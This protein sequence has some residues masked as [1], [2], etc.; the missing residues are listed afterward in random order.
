MFCRPT[1]GVMTVEIGSAESRK[2]L[3]A[4]KDSGIAQSPE[5]LARITNG[6]ARISRNRA[7]AQHTFRLLESQ[8][9]TGSKIGIET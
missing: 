2:V 1:A 6:L 9:D 3:A 8:V 7:R 5:E 4:T